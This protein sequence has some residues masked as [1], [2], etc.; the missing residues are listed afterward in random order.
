LFRLLKD[1]TVAPD[2]T[3]PRTGVPLEWE[4]I[5]SPIFIT[6]PG[7]GTRSSTVLL[8]DKEDRV[9]FLDRTFNGSSGPVTTCEFRFALEA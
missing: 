7:Y 4:R 6:S 3:L 1:Q 9:T 2:D 5:L 8:I